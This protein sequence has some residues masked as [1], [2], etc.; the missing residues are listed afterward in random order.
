M[1]SLAIQNSETTAQKP[2][3]HCGQML[4]LLTDWG[5]YIPARP[6]ADVQW[7]ECWG[8][9]TYGFPFALIR[10]AE[11]ELAPSGE[12]DIDPESWKR[13]QIAARKLG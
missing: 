2:A 6:V 5:R 4:R 7:D 8:C 12:P 11:G 9:Y 1:K 10:F 3:Y 13:V